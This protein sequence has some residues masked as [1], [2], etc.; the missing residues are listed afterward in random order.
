LKNERYYLEYDTVQGKQFRRAFVLFGNFLSL[1]KQWTSAF[2]LQVT[3]LGHCAILRSLSEGNF[4]R[5]Q[6]WSQC[7]FPVDSKTP[8]FSVTL[9]LYLNIHLS[10]EP[11]SSSKLCRASPQETKQKVKGDILLKKS[12]K[13][14]YWRLAKTFIY[15]ISSSSRLRL[16]L[17]QIQILNWM[18]QC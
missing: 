17:L 15:E 1:L 6:F 5:N 2:V 10:L 8:L 9:Y 18:T 12:T 13:N 11:E 4:R 7:S 3:A 16:H 14:N